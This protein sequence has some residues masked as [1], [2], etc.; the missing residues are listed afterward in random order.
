[1]RIFKKSLAA[2]LLLAG[3][4]MVSAHDF[5]ATVNGQKVYF[6]IK[7]KTNQTVEVTYNGSIAD[8][9]I[10][11]VEGVLEIP[12]KVKH[13]NV[14]YSVT[15][16]GAKSFAG[17]TK[18][19]SVVFP[20]SVKSIGDFAFEGCVS[21]E[22]IVFPGNSVTPGQGVFFKCTSIKNV[23]LGSDWKSVDLAMFRW[24]DSLVSISIPAKTEKIQ[25]LK[26]LKT[27]RNIDVDVNNA[28]FMSCDGVLYSKDGKT[29]Y[30]CPRSYQGSLKIKEGTE[31]VTKGAMIDCQQITQIDFPESI[32]S[33]SF[34][35][36]SRMK[37]LKAIIIRGNTV[38]TTAYLNDEGKFLIQTANESL[39]IVVLN[40]Q[41]KEFRTSLVQS[42]GEYTETKDAN[43][44][45]YLVEVAQMPKTNNVVG[46]KNFSKYE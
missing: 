32:K 13:N 26:T 42:S 10:S 3:C 18:L 14:V 15:G 25:H 28:K 8:K 11:E 5:T 21:L 2:I 19:K 45:P 1:M 39:Q 20:S 7:S 22:S 41:K 16:V 34:R 12:A 9:R 37:D 44:T 27:L 43:S 30:S 23:T 40:S 36:T 17:A 46:V 6:N 24:S 38:P 33:F 35:E 4:S 29:L 31:M